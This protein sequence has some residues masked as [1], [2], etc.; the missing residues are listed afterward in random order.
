MQSERPTY[1]LEVKFSR[2]T[3]VR[4][5]EIPESHHLALDGEG[6]HESAAGI[7]V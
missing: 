4:S 7:I 2:D 1:Y 3:D 5:G 6:Q